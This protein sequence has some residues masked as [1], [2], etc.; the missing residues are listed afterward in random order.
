M[1]IQDQLELPESCFRLGNCNSAVDDVGKRPNPAWVI[2]GQH[3][4][5]SSQLLAERSN[6][7]GIRI[8]VDTTVL[9]QNVRS[10]YVTDM[11]QH[12]HALPEYLYRPTIDTVGYDT[13]RYE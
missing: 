12:F 7:D 10:P 4:V 9:E 2:I 3:D 13:I 8:D 5:V 11:R 6:E 1:R